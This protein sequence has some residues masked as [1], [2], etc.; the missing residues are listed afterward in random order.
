MR[1]GGRDGVPDISLP[2]HPPCPPRPP[3]TLP[4]FLLICFICFLFVGLQGGRCVIF[5][6]HIT[7]IRCGG[8]VTLHTAALVCPQRLIQQA[9][10]QSRRSSPMTSDLYPS[11]QGKRNALVSAEGGAWLCLAEDSSARPHVPTTPHFPLFFA[12]S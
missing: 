5:I 7:L 11:E 8:S 4:L 6:Y 12:S 3:S 9:C 1:G 2:P 10:V